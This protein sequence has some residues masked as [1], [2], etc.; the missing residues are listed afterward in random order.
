M[1]FSLSLLLTVAVTDD[2][3]IRYVLPAFWVTSCLPITSQAK[4]MPVGCI[5][6]VK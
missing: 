5:H 3:T 1:D 2:T 6:R 4:A